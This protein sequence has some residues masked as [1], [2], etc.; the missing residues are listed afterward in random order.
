MLVAEKR[1][2][3]DLDTLVEERCSLGKSTIRNED[4]VGVLVRRLLSLVD[5]W[6]DGVA[7]GDLLDNYC[8]LL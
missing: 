8:R 4:I 1:T 2:A 6:R 5:G 3:L 7:G